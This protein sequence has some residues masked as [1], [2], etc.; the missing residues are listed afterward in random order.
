MLGLLITAIWSWFA[1]NARTYLLESHV[2]YAYRVE[3]NPDTT[4]EIMAWLRTLSWCDNRW[5]LFLFSPFFLL[6]I[7]ALFALNRI[8]SRTHAL[9]TILTMTAFLVT[10]LTV[11]HVQ[12]WI[13]FKTFWRL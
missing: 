4:L 5:W 1:W 8:A 10:T 3:G 9:A 11:L 2:Q 13:W 7:T 12:F 6:L